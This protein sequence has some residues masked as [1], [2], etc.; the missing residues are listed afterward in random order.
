MVA[1][2]KTETA[3]I[4]D[5]LIGKEGAD[6]VRIKITLPPLDRRDIEGQGHDVAAQIEV[7]SGPFSGALKSF[8]S[9]TELA[10]FRKDIETLY[11]TL[12][13]TV[14][15]SQLEGHIN[16]KWNLVGWVMFACTAMLEASSRGTPS[17]ILISKSIRHF[18][19]PSSANLRLSQT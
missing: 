4:V 7:K 12:S 2:L 13:G 16:L 1:P 3:E 15:L 17:F 10:A 19:Q 5:V 11:K 18:Y 6:H 9:I 14:T 8:F